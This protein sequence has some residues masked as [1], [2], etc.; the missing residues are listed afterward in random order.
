LRS[1]EFLASLISNI[2]DMTKMEAGRMEY[3]K[4]ETDLAELVVSAAALLQTQA[5]QYGVTLKTEV[6]PGVPRLSVDPRP[7]AG[8]WP[9]WSPTP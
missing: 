3:V 4:T 7:C 6:Q 1:T 9:T 5:E 8:W 2:L